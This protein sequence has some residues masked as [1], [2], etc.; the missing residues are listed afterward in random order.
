MGG[1]IRK[2]V[3]DLPGFGIYGP[4]SMALIWLLITF[5]KKI[6]PSFQNF[7]ISHRFGDTA[8]WFFKVAKKKFLRNAPK[9][10]SVLSKT[11]TLWEKYQKNM[12][13]LEKNIWTP[14]SLSTYLMA[15]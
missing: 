3:L 2:C 5:K 15:Q 4:R 12:V 13:P 10:F 9:F 14:L 8:Y 7:D 1:V 6:L 11:S